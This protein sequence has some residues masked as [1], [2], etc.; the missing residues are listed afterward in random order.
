M[1][2]K[3][4]YKNEFAGVLTKNPD[5]TFTYQYEKEYMDNGGVAISMALPISEESYT[6]DRLFPF[7]DGLIPEGWMLNLAAKELR[8]NPLRDRFELLLSTCRDCIGAVSIIQEE[9]QEVY[10]SKQA[11]MEARTEVLF[12]NE[13]RC[14]G[15][16]EDLDGEKF[17]HKKCS[18][19]I[20]GKDMP[21]VIG[22]DVKELEDLALKNIN[23]HLSITGVQKKLSL[24][25]YSGESGRKKNRL[26]V[27][28]LEGQFIFKPRGEAPHLPENE[29]LCLLMAK[30]FGMEI[31]DCGLIP[32]DQDNIG[33]IAKRFDR[34]SKREKYHVEDLCQLF[35]KEPYKKYSGSIEQVGKLVKKHCDMPGENL[36]RLFQLVIFSYVTGNVDLHLKNISI[37]YESQKRGYLKMLS[38]IYDLLSTDLYLDDDEQ[39][40]LAING[41]KNVTGQSNFYFF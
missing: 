4:L 13:N 12:D 6:S 15:C 28:N 29:H 32:I 36:F 19:K 11:M 31:V 16:Y 23:K 18:K 2:A 8:L 1:R 26:T 22:F 10:Q 41:K 35:E 38:P 27:T 9:E 21:P 20:F 37:V 7:F 17:Y 3:I 40:A 30:M 25:Y 5:E 39:S 24:D 33:F 14:L 34:G